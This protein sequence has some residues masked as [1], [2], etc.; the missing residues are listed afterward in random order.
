MLDIL[1]SYGYNKGMPL[2]YIS[3]ETFLSTESHCL[4]HKR[5]SL[6]Y[7]KIFFINQYCIKN[8][9]QNNTRTSKKCIRTSIKHTGSDIIL[10]LV[11]EIFPIGIESKLLIF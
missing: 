5:G 6:P 1:F 2:L 4:C 11:Y 7:W 8:R 10:I 3:K 9:Y